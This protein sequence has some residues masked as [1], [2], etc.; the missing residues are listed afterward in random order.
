[1]LTL[2]TP[3][4]AT[5]TGTLEVDSAVV[6]GITDTAPL[7]GA[8]GVTGTG[9]PPNTYVESIDST[10]QITLTKTA[11]VAGAQLLT[12]T[13]QPVTMTEARS[14]LRLGDDT[15]H[16][17]TVAAMIAAAVRKCQTN[18]RRTFL[19]STWDYTLNAF[20][21]STGAFGLWSSVRYPYE[22][23]I[24]IPNPPLVSVTTFSYV[25]IGGSTLTLAGSAYSFKPGTP[26]V[27]V[28]AYG[29]S[30]PFTRGLPGD[31]AIR[32]V[33]GYGTAA[34]VPEDVK[35]AILMMVGHT[36]QNRGDE[37]VAMPRVVDELL[38][39]AEWGSYS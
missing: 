18:V 3:P 37:D 35:L 36:F 30:W 31:L 17:I 25:D 33:A 20:P 14:H 22:A 21:F 6:A 39:S 1:M 28:P 32:Y 8:V 13:L 7:A 26:G 24:R 15:S 23:E 16:D 27:I 29:T 2:V 34:D 4:R 19:T 10:S 11:T 38:S 9:I 5:A 12:F